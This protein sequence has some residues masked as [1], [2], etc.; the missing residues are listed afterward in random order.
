MTVAKVSAPN[1]RMVFRMNSCPTADDMD[2]AKMPC[3]ASGW[4]DT[5]ASASP[6]LLS[7]SSHA[8]DR[9]ALQA[10]THSIWLYVSMA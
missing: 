9:Q 2:S 7:P 4:R 1:S 10:V 3:S 5:K 6:M 8:A